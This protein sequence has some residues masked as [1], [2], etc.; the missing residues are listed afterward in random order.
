MLQ[1]G[2]ARFQAS[3]PV[4]WQV[5]LYKFY[6]KIST[7][8]V[9]KFGSAPVLDIDVETLGGKWLQTSESHHARESSYTP[10]VRRLFLAPVRHAELSVEFARIFSKSWSWGQ[11]CSNFNVHKI[12]IDFF[13]LYK[14]CHHQTCCIYSETFHQYLAVWEFPY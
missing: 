1:K 11:V 3:C 13:S 10:C 9:K 7:F 12:S 6:A 5:L 2:K 4:W 8:L 14:N